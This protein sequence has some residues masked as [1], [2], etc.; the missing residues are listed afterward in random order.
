[1]RLFVSIAAYRDPDLGPTIADC[2]AKAA[3]P[4]DLVFGICWQ[5]DKGEKPPAEFDRAPL[6]LVDC[7]WRDSGGAC[8]ARAE[9]MKLWR[10]E[11]WLLQ[12]DSHCRFTPDWDLALLAQAAACG[13][14]KPLLSANAVPFDP[15]APPPPGRPTCIAFSHFDEDGIVYQSSDYFE[16]GPLSPPRRARFLSAHFLFAPGA[17]AAEVPY[18]PALYFHGEEI[19]LALRAFT[20][21]YDLF[22]PTRHLLWHHYGRPDRAKHWLDHLRGKGVRVDWSERD[23]AS[24]ARL[25]R[26]LLLGEG[27]AFGCGG[28]RSLADYEAY[29]GVNFRALTATE[30]A[31]RGDE[32]PPLAAIKPAHPAQA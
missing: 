7:D 12:I 30:A 20:H 2:L 18:D 22:H 14:A 28:A 1:M 19:S 6:R 8:W 31:R 32:P 27:G 3:R 26:L 21:G 17:F 9:V 25:R 5:H 15:P 23:A 29:A 11:D 13:A 10:G 4:D 16:A 24:R